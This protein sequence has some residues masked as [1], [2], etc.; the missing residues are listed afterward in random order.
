MSLTR[1]LHNAPGPASLLVAARA[2]WAPVVGPPALSSVSTLSD[3]AWPIL[4]TVPQEILQLQW[5]TDPFDSLVGGLAGT[6]IDAKSTA[7]NVKFPPPAVFAPIGPPS[8]L[9]ATLTNVRPLPVIVPDTPKHTALDSIFS[10]KSPSS[11]TE[12]LSP[13]GSLTAASSYQDCCDR[14][15]LFGSS[16]TQKSFSLLADTDTVAVE[17]TQRFNAGGNTSPTRAAMT[18]GV[19]KSA[20]DQEATEDFL[21]AEMDK[22]RARMQKLQELQRL[23]TSTSLIQDFIGSPLD[24]ADIDFSAFMREISAL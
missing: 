9:T 4:E 5:R 24:D 1:E 3:S 11:V 2:P 18:E 19:A 20:A 7:N 6:K 15:E 17:S 14:F 12:S 23:K 21:R 22:C 16:A 13:I 10:L 8:K